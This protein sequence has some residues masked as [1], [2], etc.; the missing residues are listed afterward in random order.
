MILSTVDGR[1]VT[2]KYTFTH[3]SKYFYLLKIRY[4]NNLIHLYKLMIIWNV[5][6]M[7]IKYMG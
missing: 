7:V 1:H 2:R 4:G 5:D 6:W 3:K